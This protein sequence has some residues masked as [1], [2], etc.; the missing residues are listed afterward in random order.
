MHNNNFDNCNFCDSLKHSVLFKDLTNKRFGKLKVICI[1][2][3]KKKSYFWKCKCDCGNIVV[4]DG[5]A[6]KSG[7]TKSC[8]CAHKKALLKDLVGY[9]FGRLTVVAYDHQ[10]GSKH[11]WKC[12]CSCG[13][14]KIAEGK[15][16]RSGR[17]RSCGCLKRTQ[18][19][20]A[21]K[22][23]L[24]GRR[25]GKLTV[26][27]RLNKSNFECLCDC[28]NK[29]IV[30]TSDLL[31]GYKRSCGCMSVNFYGSKE[32]LELKSFIHSLIPNDSIIKEKLLF[33]KDSKR[34]LE[35]DMYIPT[36]KLGIEYNG[37][38][39]HASENTK[40]GKNKPINY[41]QNKFLQAKAQGIHLITIFDKDYF[42]NREWV[43]DIIRNYVL[44]I[45]DNYDNLELNDVVYTNNDYDD[46]NWLRELGYTECAQ[47]KPEYYIYTR[48]NYKVYRCGKTKWVRTI[49][50]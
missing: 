22:Y 42:E 30:K 9:K 50:S 15:N 28:G 49:P 7:H 26:L 25:F 40:L 6:L 13:N 45:N 23:D 11:Y 12:K 1:D 36:L 47:I 27:H 21:Q 39:F 5:N 19:I 29:T 24:I 14:I 38:A 34:R 17:T 16:L 48:Y 18:H 33:N 8:G 44:G 3:K 10:D 43:L 20:S 37:S 2:H 4:V 41:H 46:G 31:R 35:I 32:E